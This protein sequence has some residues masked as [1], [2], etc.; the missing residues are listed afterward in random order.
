MPIATCA[1]CII[2]YLKK[3]YISDKVASN[4]VEWKKC[5]SILHRIFKIIISTDKSKNTKKNAKIKCPIIIKI[6]S[7]NFFDSDFDLHFGD[8]RGYI[9]TLLDFMLLVNFNSR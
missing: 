3:E 2:K 5:G 4:D 9:T 8:L 7:F 1:K 6:N